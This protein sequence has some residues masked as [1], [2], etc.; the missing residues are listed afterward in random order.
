[1]VTYGELGAVA[2]D[3]LDVVGAASRSPSKRTTTVAL[4]WAPTLTS[5][6]RGDGAPRRRVPVT[7]DEDRLGEL[8]LGGHVDGEDLRRG[9]PGAGADPVG[10]H[11]A[12]QPALG[13]GASTPLGA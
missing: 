3:D 11:E 2:D 1:M 7:V 9:R 6:W 4:A 10:R 8:G 12:G 13:V 5:S